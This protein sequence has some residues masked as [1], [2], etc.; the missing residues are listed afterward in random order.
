MKPGV[1]RRRQTS[2]HSCGPTLAPARCPSARSCNDPRRKEHMPWAQP[3]RS[4]CRFEVDM[5]YEPPA[6]VEVGGFAE[7]TCSSPSG[8][9][10]RAG[11]AGTCRADQFLT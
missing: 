11:T 4:P 6:L 9:S 8:N 10:P 7:L 1:S 5:G 2:E 3:T